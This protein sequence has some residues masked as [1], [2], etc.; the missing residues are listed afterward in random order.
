VVLAESLSIALA[1]NL[2]LDEAQAL[3]RRAAIDARGTREPLTVAVRRAAQ[4]QGLDA[5][6]DWDSISDPAKS[7][8]AAGE[9]IDRIL[10]EAKRIVR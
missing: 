6:I 9:F 4:A 7:L 2:P 3:V 10:D 5:G 1:D 8:G